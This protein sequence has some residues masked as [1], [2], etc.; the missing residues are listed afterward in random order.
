MSTEANITFVKNA[1][2]NFLGGNVDAI[3]DTLTDD[4]EW[5]TPGA[6]VP[7]AGTRHGK[8]EVAQFFQ[9]VAAT[10]DFTAFEPREYVASGDTVVAIGY[11]TA[12]ARATGK[13]MASD[14]TMVWKIRDGKLAWFREFTD[15]QA[16]AAAV[17]GKAA[18]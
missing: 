7:T 5:I 6:G 18:A 12:I 9:L 15:S 2:A 11:Y 8:A 17:T 1:Y 4:V 13:A 16:L 14:W 10:W 3:L